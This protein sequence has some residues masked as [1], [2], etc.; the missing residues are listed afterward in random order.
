MYYNI[1]LTSLGNIF[2]YFFPTYKIEC[3]IVKNDNPYVAVL[4]LA[5]L[6]IPS[7]MMAGF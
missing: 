7:N 4:L 5:H 6:N 3:V 2:H 1:W